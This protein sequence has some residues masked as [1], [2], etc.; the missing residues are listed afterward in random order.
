[1]DPAS[2]NVIATAGADHTVKLFDR[3]ASRVLASLTGHTKKVTS[4]RLSPRSVLIF[5]FDRTCFSHTL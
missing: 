5:K 3:G 1:M 4:E 2:P